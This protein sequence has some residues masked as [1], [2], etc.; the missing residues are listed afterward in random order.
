MNL[1][2]RPAIAEEAPVLTELA[3]RSKR[4]WGYDDNFMSDASSELEIVP[5]SFLTRQYF[6]LESESTRRGFYS[7]EPLSDGVELTHL[8]VVPERLRQGFG[9]L[10]WDHA[11]I[12]A[13]QAGHRRMLITSDPNAKGFYIAMGAVPIGAIESPVMPGRKLP[14]LEFRL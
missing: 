4:V 1:S 9:R 7:L 6:V 12:T 10:L 13:R 3:L 8:F 11:V 14:F 2:I 5:E